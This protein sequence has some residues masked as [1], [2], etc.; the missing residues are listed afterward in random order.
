VNEADRNATGH[1]R[2]DIEAVPDTMQ[3]LEVLTS[4]DVAGPQPR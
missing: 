3:G 1:G 4:L 2:E